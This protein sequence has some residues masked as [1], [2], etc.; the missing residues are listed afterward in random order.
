MAKLGKIKEEKENQK[1]TESNDSPNKDISGITSS[2][3]HSNEK[4]KELNATITHLEETLNKAKEEASQSSNNALK[5]LAELEN[6]KK[7]KQ[8]EVD[9]FKKYASESVVLEMLSIL[10][11][12][13][14][15]CQMTE[16][17]KKNESLTQFI[18]G[19]ELILKQFQDTFKKLNI[20]E[21]NPLNELFDPNF[22]QAISQEKKAGCISNTVINVMQKGYKLHDKLIRPAMVSVSE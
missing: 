1:N 20:T 8:Q 22:H 4:I 18:Q 10:D 16:E 7:R 12:F 9:T 14:L 2:E 6:F 19:F 15:A 5:H 11:T 13:E 3:D 21:V 17:Q